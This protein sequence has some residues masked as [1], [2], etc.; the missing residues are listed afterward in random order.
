[1]NL[2]DSITAALIDYDA[3]MDDDAATEAAVVEAAVDCIC[4]IR[5][6]LEA[7]HSTPDLNNPIA[8]LQEMA[9]AK[10]V[11][12]PDYQFRGVGSVH[13]PEFECLCAFEG[14]ESRHT[15]PNKRKAKRRAARGLLE[16]LI[17]R[18]AS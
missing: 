13:A 2:R 16:A 5:L 15:A 12:P 7:A 11:E 6:A 1:M 3:V 9:Q 17:G 4:A 14:R 10:G 18:K 8:Q